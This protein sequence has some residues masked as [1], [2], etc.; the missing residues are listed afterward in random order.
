LEQRGSQIQGKSISSNV[1]LCDPA[2]SKYAGLAQEIGFWVSIIAQFCDPAE[3]KYA[4]LAQE[5][6]FWLSIIAQFC[7][8][9]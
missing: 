2:E 9:W 4:G 3:S 7:G 6:G 5:I 1:Q 8:G